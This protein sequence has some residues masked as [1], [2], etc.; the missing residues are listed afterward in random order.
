SLPEIVD[1][2]GALGGG[3]T[4]ATTNTL[5]EFDLQI[6][7]RDLGLPN[8]EAAAAAAGIGGV[9]YALY[10]DASQAP[11]LQMTARWDTADDG[12][13]FMEAMMSRLTASGD[14]FQRGDV[15]VAIK[16]GGQ[17]YTILFAQ[18]EAAL[19]TAMAA[20]P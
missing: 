2:A 15:L 16:G 4:T 12:D 5:G 13:D 10:E 6:M 11:L 8:G 19:R 7:L 9:R 14:I 17:E 1:L 20:L 18:E 3:W